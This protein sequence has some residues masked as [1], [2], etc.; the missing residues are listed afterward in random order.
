MRPFRRLPVRI[1]LAVISAGLTFA[2]LLLFAVV[3]GIFAGRQVRTEFDDELLKTAADLQ[4]KL[5]VRPTLTGL[6]L[7][8]SPEA[9]EAVTVGNAAAKIV[10]LQ[11]RVLGLVFAASS[12]FSAIVKARSRSS[13]RERWPM[14]QVARVA[15]ITLAVP[16]TGL[17]STRPC[18][19]AQV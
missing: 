4:Q 2:I 9:I 18:R 12:T 13:S 7:M 5:P 8:V 16:S 10:D 14:A 6:R 17:A 15:T 19:I 3:I 1:R 11:G